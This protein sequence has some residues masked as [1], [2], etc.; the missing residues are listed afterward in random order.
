MDNTQ[1][2]LIKRYKEGLACG[3]VPYFDA[4]EFEEIILYYEEKEKLTEA[5]EAIDHALVFHRHDDNI[6]AH[7]AKILL[8]F[9]KDEEAKTLLDSLSDS[10]D[11]VLLVKA[12]YWLTM[13]EL[14]NALIY[15]EKVMTM[16][17]DDPYTYLDL[18]DLL[19]SYDEVELA[20]EHLHKGL[21]LFPEN[22]LLLRELSLLNE[23]ALQWKENI[24]ILNKLIDIDPYSVTYW[25]SLANN[26][27]ALKEYDKAREACEFALSINSKSADANLALSELYYKS[28]NYEEAEKIFLKLVELNS[29]T[30]VAAM[31]T[32]AADCNIKMNKFDRAVSLLSKAI[33]ENSTFPYAYYTMATIFYFENNYSDALDFVNKTIELDPACTEALFLKGELF[34]LDGQDQ[35]ASVWFREAITKDPNKVF[36]LKPLLKDILTSND[37]PKIKEECISLLEEFPE[38]HIFNVILLS[39]AIKAIDNETTEE[40]ML[41]VR[42]FSYPEI[43]INEWTNEMTAAFMKEVCA[44]EE[45]YTQLLRDNF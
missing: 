38:V 23:Q 40:Y 45:Q 24:A 13:D 34:R 12:E 41:I 32:L 9:E 28:D 11:F 36:I 31:L 7:K 19:S 21:K 2:S 39:H 30:E 25:V 33:S 44:T 22:E 16:F 3:K 15:L 10:S 26:Y 27:N 1:K 20:I 6:L 18:S 8:T 17:H 37:Y 35:L 29:H 14:E 43:E 42:N 5:E 4:E